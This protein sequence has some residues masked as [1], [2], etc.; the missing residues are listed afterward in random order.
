MWLQ[1]LGQADCCSVRFILGLCVIGVLSSG[2]VDSGAVESPPKRPK[3]QDVT[4][5]TELP[6]EVQAA[7]QQL[8]NQHPGLERLTVKARKGGIWGVYASHQNIPKVLSGK[9]N[10]PEKLL[11]WIQ[12]WL[13]TAEPHSN[14]GVGPSISPTTWV[15]SMLEAHAELAE[16]SA[17]EVDG[18][19]TINALHQETGY[20]IQRCYLT[21]SSA[22][23]DLV[24]WIQS[25]SCLNTTASAPRRHRA[26][27]RPNSYDDTQ[28]R[29][30]M[31][32]RAPGPGRTVAAR[33]EPI[34]PASLDRQLVELLSTK[35]SK[36]EEALS[37][38]QKHANRLQESCEQLASVLANQAFPKSTADQSHHSTPANAENLF[39]D[40]V[41]VGYSDVELSRTIFNHINTVMA[42]VRKVVGEDAIKALQL[43]DRL[44]L[45][46][47]GQV[48]SADVNDPKYAAMCINVFESIKIFLKDLSGSY[49]TKALH[50]GH[51]SASPLCL[52]TLPDYSA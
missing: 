23:T 41:G 17:N 24:R 15:T 30:W 35:C 49:K 32:G 27:V 4:I 47:R 36:L 39:R 18:V 48:T 20:G 2:D 1:V 33:S 28:R 52:T 12:K 16:L 25:L 9:Q 42:L 21:W 29:P 5:A 22:S 8:V 31:I 13:L 44:Q 43:C 10:T 26:C 19:V 46:A 51:R 11:A 50:T 37:S 38:S 45:R 34:K 14:T 3:S 6:S 7:L 40:A